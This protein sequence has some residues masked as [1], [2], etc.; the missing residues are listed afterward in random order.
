MAVIGKAGAGPIKHKFQAG[1]AALFLGQ[2]LLL[3]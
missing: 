2:D 1:A 3:P